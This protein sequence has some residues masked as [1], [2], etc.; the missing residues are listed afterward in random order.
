M[1][2]VTVLD[3]SREDHFLDD[4]VTISKWLESIGA[5]TRNIDGSSITW[6]NQAAREYWIKQCNYAYEL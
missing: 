4:L 6:H 1:P 2:F 3:G 5:Y